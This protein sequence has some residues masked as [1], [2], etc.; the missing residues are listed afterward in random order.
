MRSSTSARTTQPYSVSLVLWR[1]PRSQVHDRA[2]VPWLL[3][4]GQRQ[5]AIDEHAGKSPDQH[6]PDPERR[7]GPAA[8]QAY[9][10][11]RRGIGQ[12]GDADP[13]P[14]PALADLNRG[15]RGRFPPPPQHGDPPESGPLAQY[16]T[17]GPPPSHAP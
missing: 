7:A 5:Q 14:R 2:D 17:P 11:T 16:P 1:R 9:H 12:F 13:L 10:Q 15:D 3:P 4:A 8:G 6:P